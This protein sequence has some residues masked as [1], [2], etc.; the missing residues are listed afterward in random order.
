MVS[1]EN[2]HVEMIT[3]DTMSIKSRCVKSPSKADVV[4]SSY[5]NDSSG[6]KIAVIFKTTALVAI[7]IASVS[8]RHLAIFAAGVSVVAG[9]VGI[10]TSLADPGSSMVMRAVTVYEYELW[11]CEYDMQKDLKR[12]EYC[13][14][15]VWVNN[16]SERIMS[17]EKPRKVD[18][19][20]ITFYE[21][22][23]ISQEERSEQNNVIKY[24]YDRYD[25]FKSTHKPA[26]FQV[27]GYKKLDF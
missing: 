13:G 10:A 24:L 21:E 9:M 14:Q 11:E 3:S 4:F 2:K 20:L 25:E 12:V 7:I 8:K 19:K 16:G 17:N 26:E 23:S 22:V 15:S 27:P 5:E 1:T 6:K 18:D